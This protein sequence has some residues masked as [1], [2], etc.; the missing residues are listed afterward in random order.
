V[1]P[2][3]GLTRAEVESRRAESGYNEVAEKKEHPLLGFLR[4]FWGL[5]AWMLELIMVLSAVLGKYSDVILVGALLVINAVLSF[6]QERRAAGVVEALRKRLQVGA[7]VRRD[8]IWQVIPARELVPGDVVRVRPGD[9]VPADVKLLTG[10]LSVDQSALTGESK[11]VDKPPASVLSSGSVVRR[12][13]GNGVVVLTGA[14]TSFGRTTELVQ[15]ARPKLHIEAVVTKVVRWL[16]V[17]VGAL[18]AVV[19]VLS[20]IRSVP[21]AEM[22]PLVLV[23]LMSAVP[24]ALPVMFTISMAVGSKELAKRGVLVTRLS[25]AE[26]AAT[27]DVLCVDKTGTITMNQLAVTEVI[28]QEHSTETDVLIAGAL[29]SQEAN[30]DPIDLAFLAA[31]KER[32]IFDN[33]PTFAPVSFAPFDAKNRRT[34]AVVE[35][36]GTKMRVMK[37]AV[38][39]IAETCGL[40]APA[41]EALEVRVNAS[42]AKGYRTLAVARGPE[43]GTP[44]LIGLVSLFDPPRPDA[45]ELIAALRGL[46]VSVKMLTGDALPVATELARGVGLPNI[47]PMAELKAA[48]AAPGGTSVDL[49]AGVDGYAE[50]FPEDKYIVVQHLQASGHVTGMT[51]DGVNDAP[52]LRQAEVGIAVSTATDVAKGAASVVLTA[53]G[54]TN[55]VAL[56]EQG[57]TIYQR[58]LTWIV[59]K[60]SRTILKASFVSIAFV[61]TG[62]FVVSVF[63][64]LLLT[65]MTD[66][67]KI[68]LSTD[69]VR[70]SKRPETWQIGGF[71]TVSVIL[72]IAMVA[73]ALAFLWICWSRFG[74][75]TSDG[76][77]YTFSFLLLLYFAVFSVV[78]ARERRAFWSTMPGKAL[79]VALA[80]DVLVGTILTRV[81]IPGLMP[82]PWSQTLAIL[83]YA[84]VSCLIV[85][86]AVKVVIIK[87]R[88]PAAVA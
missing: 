58:I 80:A 17:I 81:G 4:K 49:L 29:A 28:P 87:W 43:T 30:Q 72:G 47:R 40:Q 52:A 67:A 59:N 83:A 56:V 51:G 84:A 57:R 53:P 14:K 79:I 69:H 15:Q 73:E 12:G 60:I 68:S 3:T 1:N 32:K 62:K 10:T 26:D 35:Q 48:I 74:L 6:L 77:L 61:L 75:A 45:K 71:V 55:I 50:V 9:I 7:R 25:A 36:N 46:G 20:L 38:R 86:D 76:A 78:S 82:L 31:A 16:F 8:S 33:A 5:S 13:E 66:F 44:S 2:D 42:A 63:A 34:E 22:V 85:N 18:L 24:V 27:M 65:F 11:D 39:T 54:L 19:V 21:L 64:M 41:I 37:G 88:V 23:L 70:W